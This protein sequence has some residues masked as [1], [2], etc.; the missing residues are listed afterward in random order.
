MQR[1]GSC[2]RPL[3]SVV[4]SDDRTATSNKAETIGTDMKSRTKAVAAGATVL[5]IGGLGTTVVASA[6]EDLNPIT[7]S[8]PG[9]AE[10]AALEHVGEGKVTGTEAD[11]EEGAYEI[12]VTR[13]DGPGRR[14][15]TKTS[16]CSAPTRTGSTTTRTGPAT[17]TTGYSAPPA[18][19]G[20]AGGPRRGRAWHR[21]RGQRRGP[22]AGVRGRGDSRRRDR[23]RRL[24]GQRLRRRVRGR[25][26]H[27]RR[28]APTTTDDPTTP[29]TPTTDRTA[30]VEG[31]LAA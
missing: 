10:Q 7:D 12:E 5:G 16:P 31:T 15:S 14:A 25:G 22:D 20:R 9:Q 18:A 23:G 28:R 26:R 3:R 21:D 19:A 11:D 8:V 4:A 24:P 1:S 17:P 29:T 6:P 2:Q 30:D 27:V 13:D